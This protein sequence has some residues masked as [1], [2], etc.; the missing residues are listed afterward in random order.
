MAYKIYKIYKNTCKKYKSPYQGHKISINKTNLIEFLIQK[1]NKIFSL[2]TI[3]KT[4][5]ILLIFLQL[6]FSISPLFLANTDKN[7]NS[8]YSNISKQSSQPSSTFYNLKNSYKSRPIP[9]PPSYYTVDELGLTADQTVEREFVYTNKLTAYYTGNT[10]KINTRHWHG[11]VVQHTKFLENFYLK[12]GDQSSEL[13]LNEKSF[14]IAYVYPDRIVRK[15]NIGGIYHPTEEIF[16]PDYLDGIGV[17]YS[18]KYS[19]T[20][21]MYIQYDIHDIYGGPG[22]YSYG[23]DS[24]N[25]CFWVS[26]T[27]SSYYIVFK[28]NSSMS[29]TTSEYWPNKDY[30]LDKARGEGGTATVF[31]PGYLTFSIPA[32]GNIY[33]AF[34]VG[35]TIQNANNIAQN[36][37]SNYSSLLNSKK[38]RLNNL[39]AQTPVETNDEEINK[40]LAWAKISLD[41]LIMQQYVGGNPAGIGIWAGLHWFPESWARDLFISFP[42]ATLCTGSFDDASNIIG[43]MAN[44]QDTN[45]S[46]ITYG[47]IPNRILPGDPSPAYSSADGTPWFIREIYEYFQYTNNLTFLNDHWDVFERAIDGVITKRTDANNFIV[48]GPSV[49]GHLVE[50]WMD[51]A[52]WIGSNLV[53]N[54]PRDNRAVEIQALWYTA[55]KSATELA[56]L[57][58]NTIKAQSW[59]QFA[60]TLKQNFQTYFYN[61]S[62]NYLIDHLNVDDSEDHRI[63]PNQLFAISVPWDDLINETQEKNVLDTVENYLIFPHG[64]ATLN[65]EDI[66]NWGTEDVGYRGYDFGGLPDANCFLD[67]NGHWVG[68]SWSYHN[69]MVWPWLSGPAISSF[70]KHTRVKTAYNLTQYLT[71]LL[72]YR[73][74][75]GSLC[76]VL[77]GDEDRPTGTTSQAWS[78]AEYIRAF[79]QA[80]LGIQ[81]KSLNNLVKFTPQ[82]PEQIEYASS[83]IK[84]ENGSIDY[85]IDKYIDLNLSPY[86]IERIHIKPSNIDN[87]NYQ[88]SIKKNNE[89]INLSRYDINFY[90]NGE[91]ITDQMD[92]QNHIYGTEWSYLIPSN[93]SNQTSEFTLTIIVNDKAS[94]SSDNNQTQQPAE[95][96]IPQELINSIIA[97]IIVFIGLL[98]LNI[99]VAKYHATPKYKRLRKNKVKG[100]DFRLFEAA[101]EE[102]ENVKKKGEKY[103]APVKPLKNK[104]KTYYEKTTSKE[105]FSIF[106]ELNALGYSEEE[107]AAIQNKFGIKSEIDYKLLLDNLEE[108]GINLHDYL[109]SII[110]KED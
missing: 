35:D 82:L 6:F 60:D 43:M 53:A 79:Y 81:P 49:T 52:V 63:R 101:K 76:E 7:I 4:I 89:E 50:T 45:S 97:M 103:V 19:G 13:V 34:G 27:A 55:I 70:V 66:Y 87:F 9:S 48:H 22:S 84:I 39:L 61:N 105:T 67:P 47:R 98:A 86:K 58:G 36:I 68:N 40:A 15:Y 24:G 37:L 51:G 57:T 18:S 71:N 106:R 69:G 85:S 25:S 30:P 109:K 73:G 94:T 29:F 8:F 104:A 64:I 90:L 23:W 31:Q 46:S 108:H 74:T 26:N 99:A 20:G 77:P 54:S 14:S 41:N 56:N 78:L 42:G 28:S 107:I 96:K 44:L 88:I 11:L 91:N 5:G 2:K 16:M 62:I 65:K 17:H 33:F 10:K 59:A 38:Q 72:L 12:I 92:M 75:L 93:S 1:Q 21:I 102:V 32:D 110:F 80:Y 83:I 100:R 3:F 95:E